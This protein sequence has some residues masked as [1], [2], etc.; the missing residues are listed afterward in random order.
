[1]TLIL[2]IIC[3]DGLVMASDTQSE[4]ERGSP[5]KRINTEKL[6]ILNN[7][8]VIGGA[9]INALIDKAI[10]KIEE[11]YNLMLQN[12]YDD[13]RIL[14]EGEENTPEKEKTINGAE[15][16]ISEIHKIYNV[17]RPT[18]IYGS[19][20]AEESLDFYLMIGGFSYF[21]GI[22]KPDLYILYENGISEPMKDY[23]TIGSGSAYAE[24]LL[25][26]YYDNNI[27]TDQAIKLAIFTISEA[28]KM[29]PN[30]GGKINIIKITNDNTQI[31]DQKIVENI[32]NEIDEKLNSIEKILK[33]YFTS[34]KKIG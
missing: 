32:Q 18:F 29:D 7:K 17:Q 34:I 5:V 19:P 26:K 15:Y 20:T 2:G 16:I 13:L 9:G 30:V 12:G 3:K 11:E 33:D 8:I 27:T 22:K 31:I 10:R 21:N 1:M 28:Q 6:R 25:E 23:A 14:I 24:Y 4:F